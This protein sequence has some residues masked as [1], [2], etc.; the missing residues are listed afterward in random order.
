MSFILA[1]TLWFIV[2]I[3]TQSYNTDFEVPVRLVNFPGEY[4]LVE[5]FPEKV[6]VQS[7]GVGI[8]LLYEVFDRPDTLVLDYLDYQNKTHFV[9][10]QNLHLFDQM[11][12]KGVKTFS[13]KPDSLS[14]VKLKKASKKVPVV[15]AAQWNLPLAYRL[16][17]RIRPEP[18]SV[19]VTGPLDS[20]KQIQSWATMGSLTQLLD[21]PTT[22]ELAMDTHPPF[23]V[24]PPT[25]SVQLNP[26]PYTE[27]AFELPLRS[28]NLPRFTEIH[29]D[30]DTVSVRLLV[31]FR[32]A[33]SI[34]ASDFSVAVDYRSISPRSDYVVPML[35]RSARGIEL[36]GLLPN[37][38]KY[39]VISKVK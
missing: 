15:V 5:D 26:E 24:V 33:D 35:T 13:V 31:P 29:Y 20:L 22:I 11:M 34:M 3:N 2:T 17:G 7:N 25:V 16:T 38:V 37:R 12:E 39:L 1:V 28:L 30:P 8:K 19:L 23:V 36:I 18:D 14:F 27:L 4:Q 21:G 9:A 6:S 10:H 32:I